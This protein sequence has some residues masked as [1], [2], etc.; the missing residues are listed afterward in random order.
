MMLT[1]RRVLAGTALTALPGWLLAR[2]LKAD[3]TVLFL[4]GYARDLQPGVIEVNIEAWVFEFERRPG[5]RLAFTT[6]LGIDMEAAGPEANEIFAERSRWFLTDSER[7]KELL[8]RFDGFDSLD[9]PESLLPATDR[10]GRVSARLR[11]AARG[12][13]RLIRFHTSRDGAEERFEGIAHL[14]PAEGLSIISDIDDTIKISNVADTRALLRGS[15][16]EPFKPTPGMAAFCRRLAQK[17]GASFHYLSSSPIQLAPAL[18]GFI[19]DEAFPPGSL[20][21]RESTAW[22]RL[23]PGADSTVQHKGAILRQI[24]T[25]F[26][27]RRFLLIGD[28]GE[29]DPEIYAEAA[30]SHPDR[31]ITILIREVAGSDLSPT[32]LDAA[33]AGTTARWHLIPESGPEE[34]W[35]PL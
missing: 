19:R 27:S 33:F 10:G 17:A 32:R 13:D 8:I 16:T 25:D 21:L 12:D 3:E 35:W 6:A 22:N 1:R 24:L 4:P 20:H 29:Q 5:A 26:P 15:L 23:L 2:G 7:G 11:I 18:S 34:G 30:R 28:S 14:V 9:A 31:D